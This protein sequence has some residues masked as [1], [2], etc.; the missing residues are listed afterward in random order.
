MYDKL[1]IK[2]GRINNMEISKSRE[3]DICFLGELNIY[4]VKEVK[5]HLDNIL[6]EN[7]AK[8]RLD[9]S[10]IKDIDT[11]CIQLLLSLKKLAKSKGIDYKLVN[12]SEVVKEAFRLAGMLK[13]E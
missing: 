10:G 8:I 4:N 7:P 3:G 5:S 11:S 1:L 2:N 13:K 6:K 12:P 9:L